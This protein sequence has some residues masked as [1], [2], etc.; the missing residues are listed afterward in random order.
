[1]NG[2]IGSDQREGDCVLSRVG[3]LSNLNHSVKHD[4]EKTT[5]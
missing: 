4:Q 3:T 2:C 1:M 5:H